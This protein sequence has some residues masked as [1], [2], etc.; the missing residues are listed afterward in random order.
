MHF[1]I[2][3]TKQQCN[4]PMDNT[5]IVLVPFFT[6]NLLKLIAFMPNDVYA[7]SYDCKQYW[8]ATTWVYDEHSIKP[9]NFVNG[10][11]P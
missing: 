5:L 6:V 9:C 2:M 8:I 4:A 10:K 7:S 1:L 3:E 11:D